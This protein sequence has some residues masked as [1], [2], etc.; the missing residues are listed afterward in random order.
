MW[1]WE[2]QC[3]ALVPVMLD[4]TAWRLN[5]PEALCRVTARGKISSSGPLGTVGVLLL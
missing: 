2:R 1:V 4:V 5:S 3:A